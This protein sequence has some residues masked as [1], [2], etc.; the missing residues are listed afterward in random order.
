[1]VCNNANLLNNVLKNAGMGKDTITKLIKITDDIPFRKDLET[2][3]TEYQKIYDE[4]ESQLQASQEKP[5]DIGAIPKASA[6]MMLNLKTIK[7]KS[8]SHLAEMMIQG[9]NMGIIEITK[10]MK[11]CNGVDSQVMSLAN[12]LLETENNNV[13]QMKQ[14]L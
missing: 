11:Q 10:S 9:S 3:L 5:E 14:Y 12:N 1:M 6:Y 2:Q 13:Q 4:A 8:T 7:D